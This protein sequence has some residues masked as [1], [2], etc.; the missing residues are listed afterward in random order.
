MKAFSLPKDY[1]RRS[2]TARHRSLEAEASPISTSPHHH[3]ATPE[4]PHTPRIFLTIGILAFIAC[5]SLSI[6]SYY[7]SALEYY[8]NLGNAKTAG[9]RT[10]GIQLGIVVFGALAIMVLFTSR[11]VQGWQRLG[12]LLGATGSL[13]IMALLFI[14]S[15]STSYSYQDYKLGAR[16]ENERALEAA[17]HHHEANVAALNARHT[18]RTRTIADRRA[19]LLAEKADIDNI[20]GP[21]VKAG[22]NLKKGYS[23]TLATLTTEL[24]ENAQQRNLLEADHHRELTQLDQQRS[25]NA[26]TLW[27]ANSSGASNVARMFAI[28]PSQVILLR[29][30]ACELA[31]IAL[32]L[33]FGVQLFYTSHATGSARLRNYSTTAAQITG[34][35]LTFTIAWSLFIAEIQEGNT[36]PTTAP[37]TAPTLPADH[38]HGTLIQPEPS[39]EDATHGNIDTTILGPNATTQWSNDDDPL[40]RDTHYIP[41]ENC[42]IPDD[43]YRAIQALDLTPQDK[44]IIA[45]TGWVESRWQTDCYHYDNNQ[46]HAH[47]WLCIHG[48]WRK[49]DVAWMKTQPGGWK[50]PAVNL[51][52][53]LRTLEDHK[54]YY[55]NATK[56]WRHALAHYNG[57]GTPNYDY[58]DKILTKATTLT[59]YF[60]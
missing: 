49:Q 57:G 52:A 12:C 37:T 47:G 17:L 46:G 54:K 44:A 11:R 35:A 43:I 10:L 41:P 58:A 19:Q 30:L 38:W 16:T 4:D 53:F 8:Q 24:Q 31:L 25:A 20:L 36:T 48:R 27:A 56:S 39:I 9:Y 28:S 34:F 1:T 3:H 51:Q 50:D 40:F 33:M 21:A 7:S 18:T 15:A 45:G 60:S 14:D 59:P 23:D 22:T 13:L 6:F 29:T 26:A 2:T 5:A 32:A 42:P 55:P